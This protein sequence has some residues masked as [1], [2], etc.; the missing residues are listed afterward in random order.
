M[1]LELTKTADGL[2]AAKIGHTGYA[3]SPA[4]NGTFRVGSKLLGAQKLESLEHQDFWYG[5]SHFHPTIESALEEFASLELHRVQLE[6]L[7]RRD[8]TTT[9]RTPWGAAQGSTIYGDGVESIGTSSH[10]GFKLDRARNAKVCALLRNEGGWYEEDSEWVKVAVTFPELF[11]DRE[12][13]F[14]E[15]TFRHGHYEKYEKFYGVVLKEGQSRGK[16]E[17]LF[18]ERHANDW[19]V[20][21]A[22]GNADGTVTCT[23]TVGGKRG[24]FGSKAPAERTFLVS[25]AE[26][27]T[28]S[29]A[30][31]VDLE[32]HQEVL[33]NAPAP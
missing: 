5:G 24:S 27:R 21:S 3:I 10:G 28:R 33:E 11:T 23:A 4:S 30:F 9:Q 17:R 19:L 22:S 20:I 18:Y 26:Y 25:D 29:F 12:K 14:A 13:A 2:T 31:V 7:K 8:T 1:T 32:R 6:T 16:D 15:E